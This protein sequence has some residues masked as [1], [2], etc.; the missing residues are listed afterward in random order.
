MYSRLYTNVS[1]AVYGASVVGGWGG[2]GFFRV[3][4]NPRGPR[5]ALCSRAGTLDS[6]SS[7]GLGLRV[8]RVWGLKFSLGFRVW[9]LGRFTHRLLSSSFFG[10]YH[11]IG[12]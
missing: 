6:R 9:G 10:D 4:G 5:R 1:R 8:Y 12:F 2:V 7:A 3:Y 11:L